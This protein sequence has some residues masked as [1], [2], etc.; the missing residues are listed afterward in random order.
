[1]GTM[2]RFPV[3]ILSLCLAAP[4]LAQSPQ[5]L[6]SPPADVS[7]VGHG[8]QHYN[9]DT[10]FSGLKIAPDDASA[11][12][13]ED[14][15]WAIWI[16]SGSDTCNL[17]MGRVKAATD[18][19]DFDLAIKLLD[20]VIALRPGYAEAWNRRAT[21]YYLKQDYGHAIADIAE[22]LKREPRHFG[23]LS[24]LGMMLQ[25]IGDEK[26]ALEAYRKALDIDP[27]LDNLSDTVKT[28]SEKVEGRAI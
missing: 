24:G 19:K 28:L 25:D 9:L 18:G 12:A 10:L 7:K 27:R 15:I 23:A 26:H 21:V 16:A 17:L 4:A 8:G 11:K 20:A 5:D 13:I 1:M 6:M 22:V 14:R 2:L 3:L